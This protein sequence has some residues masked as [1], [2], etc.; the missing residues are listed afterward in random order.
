MNAAQQL[1]LDTLL[2]AYAIGWFPMADSRDAAGVHWVQP[3]ERAIMPLDGFHLSR[4]LKKTLLAE[5]FT[6]TADRAFEAVLE[7]C[8]AAADDRPDTWINPG[9]ADA[10]RRLHRLGLAHS[11]ETWEGDRLVGGLYGLALGRAFF[12]ESMF[13]RA[14]DASKVALAHLVARMRCGHFTLLDCQ[15]QTPHLASLGTVEVSANAYAALL[16]TALSGAAGVGSGAG[17]D[18]LP[19][20][21]FLAFDVPPEAPPGAASVSGPT[22]GWRISQALVQTSHTGCSTVLSEGDSLNS[23]PEK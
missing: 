10:M 22:S 21:D 19:P 6:T 7:L 8:G 20:P 15:F 23:Q 17:S 12:G 16:D 13:S 11:I 3:K 5:R 14:T 2:K 1:D 9:I 18:E 4:S